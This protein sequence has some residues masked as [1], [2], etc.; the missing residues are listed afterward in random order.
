V[1][2][3]GA[4]TVVSAAALAVRLFHN[5]LIGVVAACLAAFLSQRM[6]LSILPL[7]EI[8][9]Y[10][11]VVWAS[12]CLVAWLRTDAPRHLILTSVGLFLASTVR[13]EGCF[14]SL[15]LLAHVA[16]RFL[17]VGDIKR[18]LAAVSAGILLLF[19]VY[20]M[21][22]SL[23]YYG[24][25]QNL[26]ITGQQYA[27]AFGIDY[28]RAVRKNQTTL[29]AVDLVA[30]PALALGMAALLIRG[31]RDRVLRTWAIIVFASLAAVT[32]WSFISFSLPAAMPWRTSGVWR[33]FSSH[34]R[35]L[36]C[37]RRWSRRPAGGGG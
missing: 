11:F 29:L 2:A 20:W 31:A 12:A 15:V 32:V 4:L 23:L 17:F 26:A 37:G 24:S 18:W 33:C 19:P 28:W 1:A 25:L 16:Y 35:P 30:G 10:G 34:G 21:S 8:F 14:F 22:L 36:P 13:Y 3:F 7:S 9:F 27:D 5:R 6:I